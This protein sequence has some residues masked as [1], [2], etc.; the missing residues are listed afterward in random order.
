MYVHA[1]LNRGCGGKESSDV[2]SLFWVR[3]KKMVTQITHIE[4][5]RNMGNIQRQSR[6]P[7]LLQ[8]SSIS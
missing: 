3:V 6:G 1:L 4:H 7:Q 8:N 2:V 5:I